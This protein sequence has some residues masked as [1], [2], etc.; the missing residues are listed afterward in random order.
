VNAEIGIDKEGRAVLLLNA[1]T[2]G[3][4]SLLQHFKA[5]L[6]VR[7]SADASD[8]WEIVGDR[9]PGSGKGG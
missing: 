7:Q 3:E 8:G 1:V 6:P 9:L 4:H 5:F 2:S